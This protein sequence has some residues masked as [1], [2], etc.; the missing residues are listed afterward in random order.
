M[1]TIDGSKNKSGN[2]SFI[3]NTG[4]KIADEDNDIGVKD[5]D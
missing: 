2:C 5:L 1:K 3:N 4:L